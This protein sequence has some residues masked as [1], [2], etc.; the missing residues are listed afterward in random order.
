MATNVFVYW[1]DGLAAGHL[2]F[3]VG[4]GDGDN[5]NKNCPQGRAFDQLFQRP[6]V[7]PGRGMLA[8]GIDSHITL[9]C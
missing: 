6:G 4:T 8:A 9:V 7:F 1:S 3:I 5:D 2:T